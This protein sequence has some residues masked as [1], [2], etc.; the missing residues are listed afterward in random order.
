MKDRESRRERRKAWR[1]D[2]KAMRAELAEKYKNAPWYIRIPRVYLLKPFIA[3]VAAALIVTGAVTIL[4]NLLINT[5]FSTKNNPVDMKEIEKLSPVDKE[6]A[7]KI[8]KMPAA[9]KDETW[10][11]SVYIAGSNLEDMGENDLAAVV[12]A[13]AAEIRSKRTSES[14]AT[15]SGRLNNFTKE[16]GS[17]NLDLPAYLYYPS[18]PVSSREEEEEVVKATAKGFASTDISE[19][20]SD[21]WSDNI[22]IV[23]QTGGATRWSNS[24]VNPNRTQRFV[25]YKGEFKEVY[26]EPIQRV[27]DPKTLTSFLK[28][29]REE[30]PADHNMLILWNHGGGAFGYGHDSIYE[31]MMSLKDIRAGLEGAFKPDINKPAFDIIGFDACLMASLEVT[32]ALDG[33]ASYYALSEETEPGDGWD[34]APWLKAMSEDPTMSPAKVAREIADSYTNY[35]M[36]QNVNVGWLMSNNVTFSVLDA[37]KCSEVY[38]AW[39]D[40]SKKQL[41]DAAKDGSVLAEIGRCSNKS[42]HFAPAMYNYYNTIDLGNYLD[43]I[44]DAYPGEASRA[45]KALDEAVLYHRE[46]GSLSDATGL[47]IFMPGSVEDYSGLMM[48]LEY[49]YDICDDPATRALYYYKIA[50]CLNDDMKE[51]AGTISEDEIRTLD[52]KLFEAFAREEP[53]ITDDGFEIAVGD[54]FGDMIQSYNVEVALLDEDEGK[55]VN[56]GRDEL[57]RLDGEGKLDCEFDGSWICLDGVP[58]ATEVV[59]SNETT[60]EY[61]SRILHNGKDSYLSFSWDRDKEEFSIDGVRAWMTE[62]GGLLDPLFNPD[63]VNYLVNTRATAQLK[64][65]DTVVPIYEVSYTGDDEDGGEES[66]EADKIKIG[67]N[68]KIKEEKMPAGYYLS[69]AVISDYRGDVYYSAVVGNKLSGGKVG[70][71]KVESEFVGRDY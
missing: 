45:K 61:R 9:G 19:M 28:F 36:T 16:L 25:Y 17:N 52:T 20:T 53:A 35:Y 10:T 32:H 27:T 50:G 51:Y 68:S 44:V 12:R 31:G 71:R 6:G 22:R 58:L 46:N 4:P 5:V 66:E 1:Q 18:S 21:T 39:C 47:S 30:Y 24:N 41:A 54:K 69:S 33:F 40:M 57:A 13:Q 15:I 65:G 64:K 14:A 37:K 63:P 67:R 29:C 42:T 26:N 38:S 2:K 60:V 3:L 43:H 59:S 62:D 48:C 11:I 55:V 23:I 70:E 49:I 8:D 7:A 56:Y 34:Y